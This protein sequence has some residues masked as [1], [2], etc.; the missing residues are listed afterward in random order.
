MSGWSGNGTE[1]RFR[2]RQPS[3]LLSLAEMISV[4]RHAHLMFYIVLVNAIVGT[5]VFNTL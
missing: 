4:T 5:D 2:D 3:I 1:I